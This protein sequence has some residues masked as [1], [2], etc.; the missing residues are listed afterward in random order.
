[1]GGDGLIH[2]VTVHFLSPKWVDVQ[3]RYFERHVGSD[4][5]VYASL[6]GI[7]DARL[8]NRFFY[9]ED[10]DGSHAEKLNALA[11]IVLKQADPSDPLVFVDGDAFPVR[12]LGPW[13]SRTL[14]RY[15][16][17]AVRRDESLGDCQP[18]PCFCVTTAGFWADIA[19]DWRPGETWVDARGEQVTDVGGNLLHQLRE[20]GV[21][22]LP[23]LRTNTTNLHPL[24][25][26]VYDHRVYHHGAGFRSQVARIDRRAHRLLYRPLAI[27][28]GTGPSIEALRRALRE[29]P[30][31][32][33]Q[34]RPR[35]LRVAARAMATSFRWRRNEW[36]YTRRRR[37]RNEA[38][39]QSDEIF[40]RLEDDPAFFR[41]FDDAD[42]EA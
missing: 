28:E 5:R 11:A 42:V 3:L 22:W 34:A 40:A 29:Q 33:V 37:F 31:R 17:A 7:T 15:P 18:H 10:V 13:M 30:S 1:M 14:D 39:A 4:F 6:N 16:L 24:W 12:S 19:G 20:R 36:F 32:V 25:Y 41:L 23:L 9:A 35:H 8:R 27:E 26:G 2:L 38:K 21:T